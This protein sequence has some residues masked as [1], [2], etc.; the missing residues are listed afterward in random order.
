[1][2]QSLVQVRDVQRHTC[3]CWKCYNF[4]FL[5]DALRRYKL[6]WCVVCPEVATLLE[7]IEE[8]AK[9]LAP[10]WRTLLSVLFC[11]VDPETG[12]FRRE[13]CEGKCSDCDGFAKL[14]RLACTHV[15]DPLFDGTSTPF[16][17]LRD[18]WACPECGAP[19]SAFIRRE[20]EEGKVEWAQR[21]INDN[22]KVSR[23]AY[24]S[25]GPSMCDVASVNLPRRTPLLSQI[26]SV[27]MM[28]GAY[29]RLACPPPAGTTTKST[30]LFDEYKTCVNEKMVWLRVSISI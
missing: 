9:P 16:E 4:F 22:A 13:C 12:F 18:S 8:R 24:E 21:A 23:K 29:V 25:T 1:M 17:E 6:V 2:I 26:C 27:E 11:G 3:V 28:H 14:T 10:S 5:F 15:Y 19:K 7:E 30:I 20:K